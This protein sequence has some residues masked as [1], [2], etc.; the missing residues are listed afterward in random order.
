MPI[1]L[2]KISLTGG[3]ERE[4]IVTTLEKSIPSVNRCYGKKSWWRWNMK[5]N[6]TFKLFLN[7][8][9]RV[10][11]VIR[12]AGSK[13]MKTFEDCIIQK[14]KNLQ[15]SFSKGSKAGTVTATFLLK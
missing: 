10:I 13:K 11:K 9:G 14:L 7:S 6:L 1:K 8:S 5:G 2:G 15:F 3:L 12:I 4:A